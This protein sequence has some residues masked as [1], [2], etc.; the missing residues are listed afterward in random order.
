MHIY[1]ILVEEESSKLLCINTNRGLFKFE[2]LF[3][4]KVAPAI[5]QQ[6]MNTMLNGFDFAVA[7]L[8]DILIKSQS[9]GEHKDHVHMVFAQIQDYGIKLKVSKCTQ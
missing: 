2:R 6:V 4:V 3:G 8:D 7:Y 9:L 5:F 1:K